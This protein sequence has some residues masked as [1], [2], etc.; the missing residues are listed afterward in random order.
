MKFN[1]EYSF[2]KIILKICD[3]IPFFGKSLSNLYLKYS[4]L[5]RL[6]K[7][8]STTFFVYWMAKAPLIWF[9]SEILGLWYILSAFIV[10]I[11]VTVIGFIFNE[12]WIWRKGGM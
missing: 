5:R 11:I 10:G 1:K 2:D 3:K 4:T 9:F 8:A 7:F 6:A 12:F